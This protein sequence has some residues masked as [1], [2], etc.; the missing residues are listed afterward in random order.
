MNTTNKP[1]L[2]AGNYAAV[3]GLNLYF[4][5]HGAGRPR[6]LLHGGVGATEMISEILPRLAQGR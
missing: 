6:L 1:G 5:I 2:S 4:K 3:N